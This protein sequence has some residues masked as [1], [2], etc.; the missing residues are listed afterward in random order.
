[1]FK[2]TKPD[3]YYFYGKSSGIKF[4]RMPNI[5]IDDPKYNKISDSAKILYSL[6]TL[7]GAWLSIFISK[8]LLFSTATRSNFV[9]LPILFGAVRYTVQPGINNSLHLPVFF[10]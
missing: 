2:T 8:P 3:N 6:I 7:F 9:F 1:M 4:Y 5:V 10:T